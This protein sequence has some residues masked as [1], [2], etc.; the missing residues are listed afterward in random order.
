[1][2]GAFTK[3]KYDYDY[4]LER[5]KRNFNNFFSRR[6]IPKKANN[7]IDLATWNIANLGVQKR[8]D[9]DL[10]LIAYMLTKFDII[11]IQ[12]IKS[13]LANYEKILEY[14]GSRFDTLFTDVAGGGERLGVIYRK[15]KLSRGSLV[16]ELDYNPNGK[17]IDGEYVVTP[18]KQKF[19]LAGKK[20]ETFFDNFNRNP[21]LTTWKVKNSNTTFMLANVHIYFGEKE[22]KNGSS[23]KFLNRVAEVYFLADWAHELEKKKNN[24]TVYEPNIILIGDMNV[25]TVKSDDKVYQALKRRGFRPTKYSSQTGTTLQEFTKYD[26]IIFNNN[27]MV[28]KEIHNQ[29][30]V[31][32][33]FDNFIFKDLW[34]QVENKERTLVQFKAFTRFAV[35]DHRPVFTRL[36]VN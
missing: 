28:V 3:P 9:K 7:E 33:D 12:E 19:N 4:D 34:K 22:K 29:T 20:V 11:A 10:K 32:V 18:K 27:N 15:S 13:Q 21:F 2:A 1:M 36:V 14:M 8:R 17:I 23:A 25:P 31:V 6:D 16:G 30:A 5:E 26:Q 24:K 35:S